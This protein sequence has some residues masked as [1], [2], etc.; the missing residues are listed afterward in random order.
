MKIRVKPKNQLGR[1]RRRG[2]R[3]YP[4]AT[5]A[6]YG[7][8]DEFA[9]KIAVGIVATEGGETISL[10]RWYS[11]ILDARRDPDIA[12]EIM[13]FIKHHGAK[14]VVQT[15]RILGCP[16]E[17]IKDYPEGETCPHCPFWATVDRF[18]GEPI[19]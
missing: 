12:A 11:D 13:E 9:S 8:D 15:D 16:H 4:I 10:R 7:P 2:F 5:L 3:G 19:Q 14:S 18:T 1:M 6:A 17:E